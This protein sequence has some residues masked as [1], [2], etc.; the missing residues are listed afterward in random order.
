MPAVSRPPTSQMTAKRAPSATRV[1]TARK[2][3]LGC[4]D[5]AGNCT[6]ARRFGAR[7]IEVD[8]PAKIKR[9][10]RP[11]FVWSRR[12]HAAASSALARKG[13][14]GVADRFGIKRTCGAI[15]TPGVF[16][17]RT[18]SESFFRAARNQPLFE[19]RQGE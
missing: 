11:M 6:D 3:S 15:V 14:S 1:K 19:H 18:G 7:A 4:L 8:Q 9:L 5:M 12:G 13:G 17:S 16:T 10:R 2:R